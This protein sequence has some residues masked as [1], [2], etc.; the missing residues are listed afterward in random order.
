MGLFSKPNL[1]TAKQMQFKQA[2]NSP[3]IKKLMQNPKIAKVLDKRAEREEFY[4]DIKKQAGSD[5]LSEIE[6]KKALWHLHQGEGKNISKQE[7]QEL[8]RDIFPHS[9]FGS[10]PYRSDYQ[11]KTTPPTP[12]PNKTDESKKNY[13]QPDR[14]S[15]LQKKFADRRKNLNDPV[16]PAPPKINPIHFRGNF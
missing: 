8:G 5:G 15:E 12:Q 14:V 4:N 10:S 6:L 1:F 9:G 7:T 2:K 16:K 13:V 3:V 11:K